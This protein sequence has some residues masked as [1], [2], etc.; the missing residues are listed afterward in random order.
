MFIMFQDAVVCVEEGK[1][2]SIL[3]LYCI[4][5]RGVHFFVRITTISFLSILYIDNI[6]WEYLIDE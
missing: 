3:Y 5:N 1:G 6:Y 2:F 4:L